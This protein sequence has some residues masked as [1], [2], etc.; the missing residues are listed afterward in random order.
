MTNVCKGFLAE[1]FFWLPAL[2]FFNGAYILKLYRCTKSYSGSVLPDNSY[3]DGI[4]THLT[5]DFFPSVV[6]FFAWCA[7]YLFN[8]VSQQLRLSRNNL[9]RWISHW[10]VLC[11]P[12]TSKTLTFF[13]F[14]FCS[15][16]FSRLVRF[17]TVCF[18]SVWLAACAELIDFFPL[19]FLIK[20]LEV[21]QFIGW[22]I[23]LLQLQS[24]LFCVS[25]IHSIDVPSVSFVE[26]W[27]TIVSLLPKARLICEIRCFLSGYHNI[28]T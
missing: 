9:Q 7:A 22:P 10:T 2:P 18:F 5:V 12:K 17:R 24:K 3:N 15:S 4:W 26:L 14:F 13:L 25:Q 20:L 6:L 27:R 19:I 1:E 23:S 16:A 28:I 21:I 11:W 8:S